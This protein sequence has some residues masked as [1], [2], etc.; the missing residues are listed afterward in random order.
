M[1]N[2]T[3][4]TLATDRDFP[5]GVEVVLPGHQTFCDARRFPAADKV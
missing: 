3:T 2:I 1:L 4:V 5:E